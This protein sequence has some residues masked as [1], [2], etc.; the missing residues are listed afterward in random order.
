MKD[1]IGSQGEP[2]IQGVQGLQGI[3]GL[4]GPT[5]PIGLTGPPGISEVTQAELVELAIRI[6]ELEN[7]I[8]ELEVYGV[9][10]E[11]IWTAIQGNIN[12]I[13]STIGEI[14]DNEASILQLNS[15]IETYEDTIESLQKIKS[16]MDA[17]LDARIIA[18][19][20]LSNPI[21]DSGWVSIEQDSSEKLYTLEDTN[22]FI[23]MIGR[24]T[25]GSLTHRCYGGV[26]IHLDPDT[27]RYGAFWYCVS[28]AR[29]RAEVD[30]PRWND[31]VGV[32]NRT[33]CQ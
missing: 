9:D 33:T 23:Y 29:A 24:G 3:R 25:M 21:Y 20:M 15:K 6:N 5:G 1:E 17:K 31:T 11:A 12:M 27:R 14:N 30:R 26:T 13:A 7:M 10:E 8:A 32:H 16:E 18:L 4:T 2:G 28:N 22:V 19:E